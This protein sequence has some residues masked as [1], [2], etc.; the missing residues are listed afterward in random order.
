MPRDGAAVDGARVAREHERPG[1]H[2]P[3]AGGGA[4]REGGAEE[5]P[6]TA[7][8][9]LSDEARREQ[10][11]RHGQQPHEGEPDQDHQE[12]GDFSLQG[13]ADEIADRDRRGAE[14]DEDDREARHERNAP[15]DHPLRKTPL[16]EPPRLDRRHVRDVTRDERKHARREHRRKPGEEGH[17]E[18]DEH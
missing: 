1:E 12:A 8:A 10:T 17:G 2:G 14:R 4:G 9:R 13:Q 3:D 18:A 5:N 7:A 6:G 15:D 16:A 11:L